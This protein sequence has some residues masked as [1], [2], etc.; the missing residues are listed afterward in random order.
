MPRTKL[1]SY[2]LSSE[3]VK[4]AYKEEE[5]D[6]VVSSLYEPEEEAQR[7]DSIKT[8]LSGDIMPLMDK[9][10]ERD[11]QD[12]ESLKRYFE[13]EGN[14]NVPFEDE[15]VLKTVNE[16]L[17]SDQSYIRSRA[18]LFR[19]QYEDLKEEFKDKDRPVYLYGVTHHSA[20]IALDVGFNGREKY[21]SVD[22]IPKPLSLWKANL[23]KK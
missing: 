10:R 8:N 4:L 19:K 17:A 6:V 16:D 15:L 1:T 23:E 9:I 20:L 2:L 5:K 11:H 18:D 22:E 12:D 7:P 3:L 21:N 14:K 13:E